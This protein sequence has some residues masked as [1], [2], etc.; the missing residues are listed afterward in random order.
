MRTLTALAALLLISIALAAQ[1]EDNPAPAS[2][3]PAAPA[4]AVKPPKLPGSAESPAGGIPEIMPKA[5]ASAAKKEEKAAPAAKDE[6]KTEEKPAP[7]EEAPVKAKR[8]PKTGSVDAEWA[9]IQQ[10]AKD[11]NPDVATGALD[12]LAVFIQR[13][14]ESGVRPEALSLLASMRQKRGDAG[15][16]AGHGAT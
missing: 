4:E 13:Y 10:A 1:A 7:V 15:R 12:D 8:A 16:H 2:D 3:P 11:A 5:E 14:P 6:P 9:F